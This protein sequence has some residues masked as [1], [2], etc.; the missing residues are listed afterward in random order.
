MAARAGSRYP[1]R[2]LPAAFDP[3]VRA[4]F[5]DAF[6]APTRCQV[7]AWEAL[8]RGRHTLVAAPTGS[9]KTL[10]AFL[11]AIDDLA[12]RSRRGEL[13]QETLVLYVSP[14]KALSNDVQRNL[15]EPLAAIRERLGDEL[16]EATPITSAVRTGDT[17]AAARALMRKRPPHILVTTPESL[18]ILLTSDGGL[19]RLYVDGELEGEREEFGAP[20]DEGFVLK[21]GAANH[22]FAGTYA[23]ELGAGHSVTALYE[24]RLVPGATAPL[25]KVR[26]R[27]KEPHGSQSQL[28][29]TS[30]S[31]SI[32]RPDPAALTSPSQLSMA[33]AQFAE[34]LRG[35]YWARTVSYDEIARRLDGLAP[36]LKSQAQVQE[37]IRLVDKAEELDR[38]VDKFQSQGP[39]ARM[40]FDRV[41]VLR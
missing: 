31:R 10:A 20:D 7:R 28:V 23:G 30:L 32:M 27:F 2:M 13:G 1:S 24:V 35:S 22:D 26:V 5:Q 11:T 19:A 33:A 29:E 40:D 4:W 25:G 41:P 37:L 16:G 18:Y 14:L 17:P 15:E 39:I 34:K 3:A 38:R 8:A 12:R 9:G 36:A 21:V 6:D